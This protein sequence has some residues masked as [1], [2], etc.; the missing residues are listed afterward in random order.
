MLPSTLMSPVSPSVTAAAD[1]KPS[2]AENNITRGGEAAVGEKSAMEV[3]AKCQTSETAQVKSDAL[4]GGVKI[5]EN[6]NEICES[7][8]ENEDLS[9]KNSPGKSTENQG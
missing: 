6:N 1:G 3:G 2:E 7:N 5:G 4:S 9:K 8:K